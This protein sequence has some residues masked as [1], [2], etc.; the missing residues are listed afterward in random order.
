[1]KVNNSTIIDG[2]LKFEL[3]FELTFEFFREPLPRPTAKRL[4]SI[5]DLHGDRRTSRLPMPMPGWMDWRKSARA[6]KTVQNSRKSMLG[7]E[8][9][10]LPS[11]CR[12]F[13]PGEQRL[14]MFMQ[15]SQSWG[16]FILKK[17]GRF[18]EFRK[19]LGFWNIW[20]C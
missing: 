3:T 12:V 2:T 11:V 4:P 14:L 19:P 5:C 6:W 20:N 10:R 7:S 16:F 15:V 18:F 17:T 1:M 9:K 13:A 8:I